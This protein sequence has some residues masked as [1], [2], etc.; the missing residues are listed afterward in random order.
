MNNIAVIITTIKKDQMM[1]K[2]LP[3]FDKPG[4][5]IYLLDQGKITPEKETFY[6]SL[7]DKGH[8][9][10]H[11]E[12]DIGLSAARNF[13]LTKVTEP[14]IMVAD[15]DVELLSNPYDVLHHF[16]ENPNMGLVG[17]CLFNVAKNKEHHYEYALEISKKMLWL[18]NSNKIDLVLNFFIARKELFGDIQWDEQLQVIEHTDFFLRLK[19]LNKW[20]IVYD[21]VLFGNHYS[22]EFR[23]NDY[24]TFRKTKFAKC[25]RI[26]HQKW[27]INGTKRDLWREI[28]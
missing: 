18:K 22:Y 27:G 19:Q 13:L 16:E 21:K 10:Y 6:N 3:S 11:I 15:D 14:Y 2:C 8:C 17:G 12:K 25:M 23:T 4:I 20:I 26:F 9:I 5:T 24:T 7:T 1:L 28:K